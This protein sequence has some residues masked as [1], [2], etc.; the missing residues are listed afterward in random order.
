MS[1]DKQGNTIPNMLK[2]FFKSDKIGLLIALVVIIVVFQYL[3]G[4]KFFTST[5]ISIPQWN[6]PLYLQTFE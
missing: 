1:K 6:V 3:T 4:G 5:A 2:G